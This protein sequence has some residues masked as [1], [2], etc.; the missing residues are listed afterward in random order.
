MM[1]S[2]M[3]WVCLLA[4]ANI[5]T[6]FADNGLDAYREGNYIQAAINLKDTSGKDPV[7]EY[8]MGRMRLYGYGQLKNNSIAMQH[9]QKA[10]ESGFLP[11]QRMMARYAL[12]EDHN[13]EQALYWFKK[14]AELND[15]SAQMYCAAAYMF[16]V[17][18]KPNADAARRYY[19]AAAKNGDS[20]AQCTLAQ[21]FLESHHSASKNLG[22]IWLNKAV[23]QK[24]PEAQVI[25]GELYMKG[26]LLERD[27][28]KAKEIVNLAVAQGYVPALYQM[29]QIAQQEADLNLAQEWYLKAA[30]AHYAPAE[31]ALSKLY[32]QEKSPLYDVHSG[33][34]WMLK[35]AQ[36]NSKEA[37]LSLSDLYKKGIGVEA[38]ENLAKEWQIKASAT[39]K[40][41]PLTAEVKAAQW[42][43]NGTSSTFKTTRYHLKGI[44]STWNNPS[45][46]KENK[47]NPSPQM[48]TV[49]REVLYK[50]QFIMVK[51]NQIPIHDYLN[52]LV[53]TMAVRS[54]EPIAFAHYSLDVNHEAGVLQKLEGEAV[55]GDA[56]AQ[57]SLAQAYQQG[58]G[59]PKDI[60]KA[61]KFY[62]L[63][64]DQQALQAE[65]N[66][67]LLYI[68]GIDVDADYAKGIRL[69]VDAAFKGNVYAQYALAQI[70]EQGYHDVSG[71]EVIQPDLAQSIVMY[72]L[73][74]SNHYGLAQYRLAE[75][76]VRDKSVTLSNN[77]KAERNQI[78]KE[79]YQGATTQGVAQASLPLAFFNAMDADKEKQQ[80][81]F[82]VAKSAAESGNVEASLLLGL[83]YDYGISV[84][85]SQSDAMHW[86][87]KSKENPIGAFTLGTY[88]LQN[89]D[90]NA[91]EGLDLL[92]KSADAGFSYANLNLAIYKQAHGDEFLPLLEKSYA[93][94]N[95]TAGL[96]LADFYLSLANTP[97]QLK[98]GQ[99][100]Y[101]YFAEQG[102]KTAQL[103]LAY[104]YENGL[105]GP[106]DVEN[107]LKW[108]QMSAEQGLPMAQYLLG[109]FY[110]LGLLNNKPNYEQAKQWYAQAQNTYAPSAVALGFIYETVY[111]DY[112]HA[113]DS[114]QRAASNN[115][116][117]ALYNAGLVY[118]QGKN[119]P[120]DLIRASELYLK[121]ANA[122]H[123]KA[124]VQLAG[125]YLN[126]S[127]E[128]QKALV[129]YK[130]AAV[131]G[132]R[133]ALYQ[134]A[135]LYETGVGT[136]IDYAEA[137]NYYQQASQKGNVNAKLALARM[138]QYGLGV[139]K[140][141]EQAHTLYKEM[142][143]LGNAY[144]QYQLAM[145]YLESPS[146]REEGIHLLKQAQNNGSLQAR[147]V[148]QRLA[149]QTQDKVSFIEPA[150][151][152]KPIVQTSEPADIMYM[153]ALNVWNHGDESYFRAM[154]AQ[155]LTQ[156]PDYVPAKRAYEQL[157]QRAT[158]PLLG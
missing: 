5:H 105:T 47:Y 78:I 115:D 31:I 87:E 56:N 43:S 107:A 119:Y 6:V 11:A 49:S 117:T 12:L 89:V 131:L 60:E 54:V 134:L 135:L 66:L 126:S 63:A 37:Q 15:A 1:K 120:V 139:A 23:A 96:L 36:N 65:Y 97:S 35:A 83:M 114:Y 3:P 14:S 45:A 57:F 152:V 146:Q 46:L 116:A 118:E 75:I 150:Q 154:L 128:Q 62:Q 132:D 52:A 157:G 33:F 138:Y 143:E 29:G 76:L 103:K 48:E 24:N 112:K 77:E 129:W 109:R 92:Q 95:S 70:Y 122:G 158:N 71:K 4:V 18:T 44:L 149:T 79:L 110:Q 8:Y 7:S 101:Q 137:I 91:Q 86:Y 93:A 28:T 40:L 27:L 100:I 155:I 69:L 153:E 136:K 30:D 145:Y 68:E 58:V 102:D 94:G 13:P 53:S 88:Q 74:A 20:V 141:P 127:T 121:A 39:A 10:G 32:L 113:L 81:A 106:V 144:A 98:K 41:T 51:P 99:D 80:A 64:M 38:N 142:S 151:M 133:D 25:L 21:N 104:M 82:S 148:L 124:M 16:G 34:L 42:L 130:K 55:L 61:I 50:P 19:I 2:S 85:P 123:V 72:K 90:N 9:F 73:A 111:D 125:I 26:N 140:N 108:Y 156:Y 17:G 147:K 67:G 84:E 59:T 22:L